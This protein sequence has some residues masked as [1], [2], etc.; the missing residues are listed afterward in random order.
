MMRTPIIC[1]I[2]V[3]CI[4]FCSAQGRQNQGQPNGAPSSGGG[5]NKI[6]G[7]SKDGGTL[8]KHTGITLTTP[9]DEKAKKE[10]DT[11]APSSENF[12]HVTPPRPKQKP[13]ESR[14]PPSPTLSPQE[15]FR[16]KFPGFKTAKAR[17]RYP[18]PV[19]ST[20]KRKKS[21]RK[22][23][24]S[25]R[26]RLRKQKRP[27]AVPSRNDRTRPVLTP[28][29]KRKISKNTETMSGEIRNSKET[30]GTRSHGRSKV[31]AEKEVKVAI[32]LIG[33]GNR[34]SPGIGYV[35]QNE[36]RRDE[37]KKDDDS[38][39]DND[40]DKERGVAAVVEEQGVGYGNT[41]K[42]GNRVGRRQP[43]RIYTLN[44]DRTAPRLAPIGMYMLE[45]WLTLLHLERLA[46]GLLILNIPYQI[47]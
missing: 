10:M 6:G 8:A 41:I 35:T 5:K 38:D 37:D 19:K 34:K 9:K 20:S 13:A 40:G 43:L 7:G 17:L 15:K 4:V 25:K 29:R 39:D 16:L 18:R 45:I 44:N 46:R 23:M 26:K 22:Q 42:N 36:A 33:N 21:E 31:K 30:A 3:L 1:T 28:H 32:S 2:L 14:G 27:V 11:M 12:G 24:T 47:E